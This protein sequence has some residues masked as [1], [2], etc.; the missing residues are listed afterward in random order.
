MQ[1]RPRRWKGITAGNRDHPNFTG[2]VHP[3]TGWR[4]MGSPTK[5]GRSSCVSFC[6]WGKVLKTPSPKLQRSVENH[7]YL[8]TSIPVWHKYVYPVQMHEREQKLQPLWSFSPLLLTPS[9]W[10]G[11]WHIFFFVLQLPRVPYSGEDTSRACSIFTQD[12]L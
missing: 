10:R 5:G 6:H 1:L 12:W 11:D 7:H 8:I 3:S 9:Q 2:T 4:G